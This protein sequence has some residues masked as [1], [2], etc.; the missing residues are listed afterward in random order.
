MKHKNKK[1]QTALGWGETGEDKGEMWDAPPL[2]TGPSVSTKDRLKLLF[3]P[4]K[5]LLYGYVKKAVR[6][7]K[8]EGRKARIVDVGCGTG[9]AVIDMKKMFG[10]SVEVIGLDVLQLQIDVAKKKIKEHGVWAEIMWFDG[11]TFPFS[12]GTIDAVYSSDVLGHVPDV[13]AWLREISRILRSGGTL[14]MFAESKLG[15]HA[16]IRNYLMENG[17][18]TDPHAKYHVSLYSK[19]ELIDLLDNTG[20][21]IKKM[22]SVF[23]AKFFVH[24]DELYPAFKGQ[25]GFL[26]FKI[27]NAI[28]HFIKKITKPVSLAIAEFYGLIEMVTIGRWIESQGYIVLATKEKEAVKIQ[29]E[30]RI[31][32]FTS[33]A[34]EIPTAVREVES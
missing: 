32:H 13:P 3:F 28:L 8:K 26:V 27:I 19:Q 25:K 21:V 20:F 34:M 29:E 2:F 14:A 12:D 9:G 1:K 33:I 22:Y 7:A 23:W 10:R 4:K 6:R 31:T 11:K 18:N 5:F 16:Y 15:K 30:E 24:P 17:L